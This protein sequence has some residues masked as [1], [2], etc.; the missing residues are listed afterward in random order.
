MTDRLPAA[1]EA[2][3]IRRSAESAGGFA[4]VLRKGDPDR[5]SLLL[6]LAE[7]GRHLACLERALQPGGDYRWQ[8]VGPGPGAGTE[9][10]TDF[11]QKRVRFDS[12]SWLI[13]LD[14]PAG[15]RFIAELGASG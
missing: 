15:Q 9:T 5:G 10:V 14:V 3:A 4:T 8:A 7:R 11:V 6:L 1:L 13:E 12:D 2:A